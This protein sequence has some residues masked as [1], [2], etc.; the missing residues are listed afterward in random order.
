MTMSLD[1]FGSVGE[2]SVIDKG[3]YGREKLI[4]GIWKT[5]KTDSLVF[6]AERRIGKTTVLKELRNNPVGNA[7]VIYSDVEKVTSP[8]GFVEA[9]VNSVDEYLTKK[10]LAISWLRNLRT[11]L[12]GVD[13]AGVCKIPESRANSWQLLLERTLRT[14]CEN[15]KQKRLVFLWDEMP[16]MLQKLDKFC[17]NGASDKSIALSV[18]D[19][20]RALRSEYE[21]LRVIYTGSIGLHHV[22]NQL[23][24]HG[25]SSDPTNDMIDIE[26]GPLSMNDAIEMIDELLLLEGVSARKNV[27]L[28]IA[29][30][31]DCVP[32]YI[33]RVIAM[34]VLR[35]EDPT[36]NYIDKLVVD[37]LTSAGDPWKMQ[38]FVDRLDVYYSGTV[39]DSDSLEIQL[40]HIARIVLN[41]IANSQVPQS[42]MEC[43][44]AIA[45]QVK[46][47]SRLT[48]EDL[49]RDLRKD[50]YL[51][52]DSDGN[53]DYKFP[54]LR[55]WWL[56]NQGKGL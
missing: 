25:L 26:I 45:S 46:Y 14:V 9:I 4:R 20:L 41:H 28:K 31:T 29:E 38:H 34:I 51:V 2:K 49:M 52:L 50:F 17:V 39:T 18:L 7:I 19:T 11:E 3:I 42:T 13:V 37:T 53:Y 48:I 12:G 44:N 24:R 27:T 55:R 16:Y 32:F 6:T 8:L 40:H 30:S 21:N 10:Q 36:E 15:Q 23:K 33:R 35:G 22:I 5:L 47:S 43:V 54:L 56:L 1:R